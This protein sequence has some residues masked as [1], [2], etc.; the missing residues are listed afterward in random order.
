MVDDLK[1]DDEQVEELKKWW[2]ENGKS[3]IAGLIIGIGGL[4]GYQYWKESK[5]ENARA[6][7][8]IYAEVLVLQNKADKQEFIAKANSL[9]DE[10]GS[11]SYATLTRFTL[12]KQ[13][14]ETG[15]WEEAI[16]PLKSIID[17]S[18]HDGYVH[19]ARI[20]LANVYIQL[21]KYDDALALVNR[22]DNSEFQSLY[23]EL[24]GDI[25]QAKGE[26]DKAR[27]AYEKALGKALDDRQRHSLISMK[28]NNISQ[29]G[30]Q[31][32]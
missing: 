23:D 28:L 18:R 4:A 10:Y 25:Y 5:I 13:Y 19:L 3:I 31:G 7:S 26:I 24:Q 6:A 14:A 15:K 16:T 17:N 8:D 21:D 1:T 9:L 12:A 32:S 11:T 20:R 27:N 22:N 30:K 2:R 29:S